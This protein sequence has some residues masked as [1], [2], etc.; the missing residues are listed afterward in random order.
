M[1]ILRDLMLDADGDL[2][3]VNGD[4]AFVTGAAAVAQACQIRLRT[5]AGEWVF[6]ER[7]GTPWL[8]SIL[9]K[10][11]PGQGRPLTLDHVRQVISKRLRET[12]G[13][14]DVSR[15]DLALDRATRALTIDASV[16]AET[17]EAAQVQV[18]VP[19]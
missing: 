6:D 7:V 15:L 17:G 14:A 3:I 5:L 12:P 4:L 10:L 18:E 1:P 16:L 9:V 19:L 13:V 11:G 8:E 2:A